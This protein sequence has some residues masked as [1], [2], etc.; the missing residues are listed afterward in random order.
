MNHS[1]PILDEAAPL[2]L[3]VLPAPRPAEP[4]APD[5]ADEKAKRAEWRAEN[6]RLA[7]AAQD[8]CLES[9]E[10]LVRQFEKAVPVQPR[11]SVFLLDFY[12]RQPAR[13]QFLPETKAVGG[14]S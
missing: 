14:R 11:L 5:K 1:A 2:G 3:K 7:I 10:S 6:R 9:F 4:A 13:H 8:G 12:H